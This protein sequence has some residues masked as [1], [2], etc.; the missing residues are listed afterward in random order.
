MSGGCFVAAIFALFSLGGGELILILA[1][2]LILFG[3]K[4]LPD[5][6]NGIRRGLELFHRSSRDVL[7]EF[8]S[9]AH[10][11]GRSVGGIY[12]K[13]AAQA[14]TPDNQTAELYDP[15]VFNKQDTRK[16][17]RLEQWLQI[18]GQVWG[19]IWGFV[20]AIFRLRP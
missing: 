20:L 7:N 16:H 14:L 10:E 15:A 17:K 3:A 2:V 1:L 13:A 4:N 9:G 8:D 11:A 12:G 6:L 19:R 5:F 18:C